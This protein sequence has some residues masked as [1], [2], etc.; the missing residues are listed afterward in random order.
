MRKIDLKLSELGV[1]QVTQKGQL[2]VTYDPA[3]LVQDILEI[4]L[5][6]GI[7]IDVGWHPESDP[8][9]SFRIVVYRDYWSNQL[10][11]PILTK[12][13]LEVVESVRQLV[14]EY[15]KPTL[16]VACS[17]ESRQEYVCKQTSAISATGVAAA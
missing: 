7:T 8:S 17:S 14:R 6:N 9:G 1:G 5:P 11:K 12:E 2:C 10:T 3:Y 13:V 4:D 16:T 15:S